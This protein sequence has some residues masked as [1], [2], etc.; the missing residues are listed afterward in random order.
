MATL[1][2]MSSEENGDIYVPFLITC[3]VILV[4]TTWLPIIVTWI[5]TLRNIKKLDPHYFD[6]SGFMTI[7]EMKVPASIRYEIVTNRMN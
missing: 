4:L 1:G 2:K 3:I 6:S 5:N 7:V